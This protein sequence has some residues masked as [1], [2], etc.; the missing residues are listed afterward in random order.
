MNEPVDLSEVRSQPDIEIVEGL[1]GLLER[2][3]AGEIRGVAVCFTATGQTAET[4]WNRGDAHFAD[5]FMAVCALKV[6]M[7][8]DHE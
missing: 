8:S 1:R 7:L 5:L 3:E 2:A 6:S 4:W